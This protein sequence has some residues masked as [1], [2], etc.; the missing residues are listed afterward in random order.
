MNPPLPQRSRSESL[1]MTMP[2]VFA[3]F[4]ITA[5]GVLAF[6]VWKGGVANGE[7]VENSVRS[8]LRKYGHNKYEYNYN[9]KYYAEP[10]F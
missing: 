3:G 10:N 5:V 2:L 9:S 4:L 1:F 7:R 8:V 6:L